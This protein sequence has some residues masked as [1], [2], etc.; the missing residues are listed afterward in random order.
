VITVRDGEGNIAY[1]G[2]TVFLPQNATFFSFGVVKAA[3]ARPQQLGLQ[4]VFYPTFFMDKN[5]DPQTLMGNDLN[6]LVSLQV[7]AGDLN[8][9]GGPQSVYALDTSAAR[10]VM[11][12]SDPKKPLRLDMQPGQTVQLPDGLGSV[13][14][15]RVDRWNRIQISQSPGKRLALGGVVL[16]LL[17]LLGSLFIRPRRVWVRARRAEGGTLVEVAALDR[18]GA[19][20]TAAVVRALTQALQ[21][22]KK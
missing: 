17:G 7:W 16:C 21:E 6:P 11:D 20:D 22:E 5:G 13:T 12:P 15:D 4:G 19:G 8:P 3:A 1:S 9:S 18:S 14:F 10:Q 2:P